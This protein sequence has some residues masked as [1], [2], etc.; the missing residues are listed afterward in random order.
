MKILCTSVPQ[1]QLE[2]A[3]SKSYIP[4]IIYAT[5]PYPKKQPITPFF[6]TQN[7]LHVYDN[8]MPGQKQPKLGPVRPTC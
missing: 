2:I 1:H 7:T 3:M 6:V 8:T 5:F 4:S